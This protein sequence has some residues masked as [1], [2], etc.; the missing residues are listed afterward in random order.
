MRWSDVL[1]YAVQRLPIERLL[2]RPPS[3]RQRLEELQEILSGAQ[4]K[5]IETAAQELPEE[6]PEEEGYLE[7]RRQKVHLT[8][9]ESDLSTEETVAYQNREIAKNLLD[10]E[11]HYA[12]RLIING[13]KCDCGSSRHLLAIESLCEEAISMVDNPDVYYRIIEWTRE[14]APKSTTEAAKSG[15]YDNEYPVFSRQTRDFRKEIIGSLEPAA[16]YPGRVEGLSAHEGGE[17]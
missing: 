13:K 4:A 11:K 12:Q 8:P 2:V 15:K 1:A 16:L 14:V 7:P 9:K 3:N 6:F 17:G 5:P 10:M